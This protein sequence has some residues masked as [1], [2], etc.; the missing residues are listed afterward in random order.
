[1]MTCIIKCAIFCRVGL[2]SD[3]NELRVRLRKLAVDSNKGIYSS[4]LNKNITAVASMLCA[5]KLYVS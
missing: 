1:M 5:V 2:V 3:P 4:M